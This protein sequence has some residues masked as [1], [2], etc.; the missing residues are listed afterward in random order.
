MFRLRQAM[1]GF[2]P[3]DAG[4]TIHVSS[5][6]GDAG[7]HPCGCR[8]NLPH[9]ERRSA[10]LGSSLRM[11]GQRRIIVPVN[12]GGGFIPAD[13]G[14]TQARRAAAWICWVHPCGC[15]GNKTVS[16]LNAIH[17]GSSLRMQGQPCAAALRAAQVGFIPADAGATLGAGPAGRP[18]GVHPCGC[19][20]NRFRSARAKLGGGSSLR[21]QGQPVQHPADR[22]RPGFIPAD[23]GA[24]LLS[25]S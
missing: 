15:R 17:R 2:I 19:R 20:G 7:V 5:P 18:G 1:R 25:I 13:A 6:S 24:T 4:A 11:Q 16:A 21:M 10:L 12:A 23:A 8:G 14:A 9:V 3:A 22:H